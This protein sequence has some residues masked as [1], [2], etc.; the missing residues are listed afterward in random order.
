MDREIRPPKKRD[1]VSKSNDQPT[2]T[3]ADSGHDVAVIG[4]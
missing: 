3:V 1:Q 4:T 2:A